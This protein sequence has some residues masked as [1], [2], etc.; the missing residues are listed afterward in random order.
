MLSCL[1]KMKSQLHDYKY[2]QRRCIA[3]G[4]L[5]A[6][7]MAIYYFGN[8][9]NSNGSEVD[10]DRHSHN[11]HKGSKSFDTQGGDEALELQEGESEKLETGKINIFNL[12]W[13]VVL[14]ITYFSY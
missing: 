13:E 12:F 4:I 3:L 11:G 5:L 10:L 1:R 8:Y 9:G 2:V 7:T 6:I 14:K